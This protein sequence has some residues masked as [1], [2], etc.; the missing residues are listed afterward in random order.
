MTEPER[1]L[2]IYLKGLVQGVGMRSYVASLARKLG[3]KGYAKNLDDG[4]VEIVVQGEKDVLEKLLAALR[5]SPVGRIDEIETKWQE[6]KK[7]IRAFRFIR[8]L[9]EMGQKDLELDFAAF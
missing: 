1:E 4:R 6:M 2:H 5:K 9:N 3:L 7:N 8:L